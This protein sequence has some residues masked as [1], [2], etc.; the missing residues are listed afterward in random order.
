MQE[1][2]LTSGILH[3][4]RQS[5]LWGAPLLLLFFEDVWKTQSSLQSTHAGRHLHNHL[6]CSHDACRCPHQ[7]HGTKLVGAWCAKVLPRSGCIDKWPAQ[8]I[9]RS[10]LIERLL[11]MQVTKSCASWLLLLSTSNLNCCY[12]VVMLFLCFFSASLVCRWMYL[13]KCWRSPKRCSLHA[14]FWCPH[15]TQGTKVC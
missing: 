8:A 7:Q 11:D 9:K 5:I 13:K 12:E 14:V 2:V 4:V 3:L 6:A 10:D 15:G 1:R